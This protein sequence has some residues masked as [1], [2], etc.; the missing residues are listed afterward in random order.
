FVIRHLSVSFFFVLT[1]ASPA[2]I[3]TLSLHDAL[4]ICW[5]A[6]SNSEVAV[7]AAAAADVLASW[8]ALI[9]AVS[10]GGDGHEAQPLA[11]ISEPFLGR[12]LTRALVPA[13]RSAG[14]EWVCPGGTSGGG[15]ARLQSWRTF[16]DRPAGAWAI[17]A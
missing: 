13:V 16:A 7:L 8:A 2:V 6:S 15:N 9:T 4:P 5:A 14:A 1:G 11:S 3:Y 10:A 17:A 12:V